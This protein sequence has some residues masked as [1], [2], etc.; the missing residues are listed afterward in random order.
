MANGTSR[1]YKKNGRLYGDFRDYRDGGGP[2][3]ALIADG[4]RDAGDAVIQTST[5]RKYV[6]DFS[7]V[8]RC[9]RADGI[10]LPYHRPFDDLLNLPIVDDV[11][12]EWL[13]DPDAAELK[14]ILLAYL[15]ARRNLRGYFLPLA[16]EVRRGL[17]LA[18]SYS[19]DPCIYYLARGEPD[20]AAATAEERR[21]TA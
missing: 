5:L 3:E 7:K 19:D 10:L 14:S 12:A 4:K 8:F 20:P 11:E 16:Q 2:Q 6:N 21:P 15:E 17:S 13:D 18:H 1:L 9:A